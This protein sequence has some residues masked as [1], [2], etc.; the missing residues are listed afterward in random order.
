M[1]ESWYQHYIRH[2]PCL[3][4]IW[5]I[6]IQELVLFMPLH[7]LIIIKLELFSAM[8]WDQTKDLSYTT[9]NSWKQCVYKIITDNGQYP[10]QWQYWDNVKYFIQ[11]RV[12]HGSFQRNGKL[13]KKH[14]VIQLLF[15]IPVDPSFVNAPSHNIQFKCTRLLPQTQYCMLTKSLHLKGAKFF[16]FPLRTVLKMS[17]H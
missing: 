2:C 11:Q 17:R 13:M 14:H 15:I 9:V 6:R 3:R 5:Y 4:C 8:G 12:S 7:G 10:A 16:F 1:F